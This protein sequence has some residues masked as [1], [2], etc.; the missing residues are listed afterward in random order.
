MRCIKICLPTAVGPAYL[1]S[2]WLCE[3]Q[4]FVKLIRDLRAPQRPDVPRCAKSSG[5]YRGESRP[6]Q[7]QHWP[8]CGETR[9]VINLICFPVPLTSPLKAWQY[10]KGSRFSCVSALRAFPTGDMLAWVAPGNPLRAFH[11]IK[12]KKPTHDSLQF[13][14]LLWLQ[15]LS[16]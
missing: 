4:T 9:E 7:L 12:E 15:Y 16:S 5:S 13:T 2:L 10:V 1:I 8:G 14:W 6:S 11:S 3:P